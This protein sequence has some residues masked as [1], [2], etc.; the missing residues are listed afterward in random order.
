MYDGHARRERVLVHGEDRVAFHD[1]AAVDEEELQRGGVPSTSAATGSVMPACAG[2]SIRHS[3]RS[4]SL[5]GS[6]EPIASRRPST[7]A[8]PTVAMSKASRTV[9]ASG[10]PVARANSTACRTSSIRLPASLLAAPSTPRPTGAPAARRSAARAMPAP[11]RAFDDGQCATPVPVVP[12]RFT[13]RSSKWVPWAS[14]TS[15][16]VQPRL[17]AYSSGEQP[18]RSR[19][20]TSSSVVSAR[21]VCSRTPLRRASAAASRIRSPVTE[22][23]EQGATATRSIESNA[24]SCHLSIAA[25]V[26]ASTAARSSTTSSGGNPPSLR[27]RSI[28][29]RAGW[30]R[31]P[32]DSA[33][34][35]SAANRSPPSRG[36]T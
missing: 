28:D 15:S 11:S 27:P 34:A 35:I 5:P 26:A 9:I 21:W 22:N 8:P 12:I 32:T 17:T 14:Q 18:N 24:G 7:S 36:N 19:Q 6:I 10:P 20:K 25:S 2:V 16:P 23:G 1:R 13:S 3:A 4:A 33:A 31:S 29:P 30:N